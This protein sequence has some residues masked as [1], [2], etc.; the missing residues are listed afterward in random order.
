[1]S[2]VTLSISSK[3][4]TGLEEFAFL[5]DLIIRPGI[6]PI[7]VFLC[8]LISASSRKPPNDILSYFLPRASAIDFPNEVLPIPGGPYR[9]RIGDFIFPFNLST[10]KCSII[11]CLT[12][13]KPK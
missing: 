1:M 8:P 11:L 7:Y 12:F 9:Q 5:I 10:A 13:S 4:K 3:T 6:A 2:L